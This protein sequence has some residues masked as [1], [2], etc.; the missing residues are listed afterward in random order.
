MCARVLD[1]TA[2]AGH[3]TSSALQLSSKARGCFPVA[4]AG[5][6]ADNPAAHNIADIIAAAVYILNRLS[7]VRM[8]HCTVTGS[9]LDV[10]F[11]RSR[12]L[13]LSHP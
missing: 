8:L 7:L 9:L 4:L 2:P 5:C 10:G 13:N 1:G 3:E 12:T 6:A 11:A